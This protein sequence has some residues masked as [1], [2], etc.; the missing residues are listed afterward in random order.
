ML[1]QHPRIDEDEE[2]E[3]EQLRAAAVQSVGFNVGIGGF[4]GPRPH[5]LRRRRVILVMREAMICI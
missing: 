2:A 1:R 4:S 5:Q 3:R